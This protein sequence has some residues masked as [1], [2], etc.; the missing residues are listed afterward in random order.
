MAINKLN[1]NI[2]T[3][4]KL[5]PNFFQ[6]RDN[7]IDEII[8][9]GVIFEAGLNEN[10]CYIKFSNGIQ[11]CYGTGVFT[12]SF[13]AFGSLYRV[14]LENPFTYPSQF[15]ENPRV[16]CNTGNGTDYSF[17]WIYGMTRNQEKITRLDLLRPTSVENGTVVIFFLAIG[18]WK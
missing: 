2:T 11:I 12:S 4:T 16:F 14:I 7:K 9:N 18:K 10:G 1:S 17:C 5:N 13:A 15:I 8:G 3:N 6:T